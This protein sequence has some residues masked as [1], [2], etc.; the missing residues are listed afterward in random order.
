MTTEEIYA[1]ALN[2]GGWRVL[3]S[4]DGVKLGYGVKLGDGVTLGD[5]VKLGNWVTLGDGVTLGD[6]VKLGNGVTLGN[7]V[8]LGDWVI[9][10]NEVKLGNGVTLDKTPIQVQCY[11][12]IV[13]PH[14]PTQI[15]VG[16]VIHD[17]EYWQRDADPDE[18]ADHP[19]CQPWATYRQALALVIAHNH[20]LVMVFRP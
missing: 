10:G 11:P 19:E 13:Y 14:S 9:L 2:K 7:W 8:K 6:R 15:G 12:Y 3:P 20:W 5:G 16:C 18:L 1:I 17:I 4:G